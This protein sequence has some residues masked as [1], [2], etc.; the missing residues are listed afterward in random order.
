MNQVDQRPQY[1]EIDLG[2]LLVGLWDGKW[3][4]IGCTLL[5][6]IF[7]LAYILVPNHPE[8]ASI[9]LFPVSTIEQNTYAPLNRTEFISVTRGRLMND[10][11]QEL[12]LRDVIVEAA[13]EVLV[14]PDGTNPDRSAVGFANAVKLVAPEPE[15]GARPNW[16]M[17][18]T[19]PSEEAGIAVMTEIVKAGTARVQRNLVQ[20]F[21]QQLQFSQ[22]SRQLQLEDLREDRQNAIADYDQRVNERLAFLEEQAALARSQDLAQS[23]LLEGNTFGRNATVTQIQA[24]VPYY[25]AG[26]IAI[27]KEIEM[28]RSRENKENFVAQ[29]AE[30]DRQ[31]RELEQDRSIERA[32]VAFEATPLAGDNFR[33]INF[34]PRDMQFAS[35]ARKSLILAG[36]IMFGGFLGLMVLIMRNA[37]RNRKA[38]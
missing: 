13:R 14:D 36:A 17:S 11:V 25:F 19:V 9:E 21:E 32:R 33:A 31:I 28:M 12:Q 24:D 3:I 26:Y 7:G 37:L 10:F 5:G 6:L 20:L 1:D 29:L 16:Q 2:D 30:I 35:T 34:D 38:A 27:E 22:Q 8:K 15:E 18:F 23:A 4:I